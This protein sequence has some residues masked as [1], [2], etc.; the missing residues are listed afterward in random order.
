MRYLFFDI[1]CANC[2]NGNGKICSFGYI[3]CDEKFNVIEQKD[4]LVN[5]KSRF[6]LKRD[7]ED[8]ITLAYE[9]SEFKKAPAFDVE[10]SAI[11]ELLTFDDQIIF[12]HSVGNDLKFIR[13]DIK[14]YKKEDF[15]IKAY[16]TQVIYRQLKQEKNDAGLEKL[17]DIYGLEKEHMHRSDYD[18]LTTMR[19]LRAMCIEQKMSI[20][21]LLEA[22]PNSFIE[23]KNGEVIKKFN[24]ISKAKALLNFSKKIKSEVRP[25]MQQIAIDD[26]F[27]ET[28]IK[29]A[30]KIVTYI[31]QRGA[32]YVIKPQ[33]CT[34][35]VMEDENSLRSQK[36]KYVLEAK[37]DK[38]K[39]INLKELEEMLNIEEEL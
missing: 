12:G 18:A 32:D 36:A 19:V 2:F 29:R 33:H 38:F 31:K 23:L 37:P 8:R 28:D 3:I 25:I 5:P 4:L 24:P 34:Y 35:Y 20:S 26:C 21:E 15:Y 1:E 13:S 11:R 9:E 10:Y 22:Y 30:R 27:E 7:G 6:Y 14:R 39:I 16:D 17:C